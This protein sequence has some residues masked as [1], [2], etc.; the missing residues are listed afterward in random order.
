MENDFIAYKYLGRY[1]YK[2]KSYLVA[3]GCAKVQVRDKLQEL[4]KQCGV[5]WEPDKVELFQVVALEAVTE[6]SSSSAP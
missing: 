2:E 6:E 3:H 4:A 1:P 5:A